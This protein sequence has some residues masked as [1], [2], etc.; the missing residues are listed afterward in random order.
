MAAATPHDCGVYVADIFSLI[1]NRADGSKLG[2]L[3]AI[4]FVP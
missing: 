3:N 4:D 2:V 1:Q